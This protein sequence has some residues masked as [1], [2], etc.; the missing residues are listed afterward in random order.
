M[1]K[2]TFIEPNGTERELEANVGDTLM[3]VAFS[4]GVDGIVAECGG[5]MSCATCHAYIDEA[6]VGKLQPATEDEKSMVQ[7]AVDVREN[8]RL[9]CQIPV[10]DEL[11]GII[12]RVPAAQY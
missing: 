8:S 3:E 9:T 10:T 1:P 12:V 5:C 6:W 2:V 7:F 4:N 11:D